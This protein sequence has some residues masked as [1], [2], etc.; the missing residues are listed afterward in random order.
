MNG[1]SFWSFTF[2][3][4]IADLLIPRFPIILEWLRTHH[5][6]VSPTSPEADQAENVVLNK[7]SKD[8]Q[9]PDIITFQEIQPQAEN[10][11]TNAGQNSLQDLEAAATLHRQPTLAV[12]TMSRADTRTYRSKKVNVAISNAVGKALDNIDTAYVVDRNDYI[13]GCYKTTL[14]AI[15]SIIIIRSKAFTILDMRDV[16]LWR[17]GTFLGLEFTVEGLAVCIEAWLGSAVGHFRPVKLYFLSRRLPCSSTLLLSLKQLTEASQASKD[18]ISLMA[19]APRP[20]SYASIVKANIPVQN[21]HTKPIWFLSV[22]QV[23]PQVKA[24][25]GTL[26]QPHPIFI[27]EL[28]FY[29]ATFIDGRTIKSMIETCKSA[30]PLTSLLHYGDPYDPYGP[31]DKAPSFH[32]RTLA[33]E[34]RQFR[35][36][37]EPIWAQQLTSLT[38]MRILVHERSH[39]DFME[40]LFRLLPEPHLLKTLVINMT[41]NFADTERSNGLPTSFIQSLSTFTNLK[42]LRIPHISEPQVSIL[43][44]LHSLEKLNISNRFGSLE[45]KFSLASVCSGQ[46]HRY[47]ES[48]PRG[49][50]FVENEEMP[51]PDVSLSN[52]CNLTE[53]MVI[54]FTLP[55]ITAMIESMHTQHIRHI[56]IRYYGDRDL[57]DELN[58]LLSQKISLAYVSLEYLR[59]EVVWSEHQPFE[60]SYGNGRY[61]GDYM[62]CF[63]DS[64]NDGYITGNSEETDG[65]EAFAEEYDHFELE[66]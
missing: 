50:Y 28:L 33:I 52:L 45:E 29:I 19:T 35:K 24:A 57:V 64:D 5:K 56:L 18:N 40:Q 1:A 62:T 37:V 53:L 41:H 3:Q 43:N 61:W 23:T 17:F 16:L 63:D 8:I 32:Q 10:I 65:F 39:I 54:G 55:F 27:Q 60:D 47:S 66:S 30:R 26:P 25:T 48:H 11:K 58:E 34:L 22:P 9:Q 4:L 49:K 2:V 15:I 14:S 12:S 42:E 36:Y 21:V 38:R 44:T 31:E 7:A 6:K 51:A 20:I 13:F 59:G 46:H